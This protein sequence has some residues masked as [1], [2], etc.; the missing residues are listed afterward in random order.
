M[1]LSSGTRLGPYEILAPLGAGGMGEVYKARDSRLERTVAIKVLPDS[2]SASADA[3][4]RLEREARSISQLSHPNICAL[5][6]VGRE[7]DVE[8]LVMEYL[9][10][11]TL[12]ERLARGPLPLDLTLRYGTEIAG[13]LSEAHRHGIVHRDLK[14]GNIMLTKTGLKLLDFGLAKPAPFAEEPPNDGPTAKLPSSSLTAEGAIVGTLAYMAPEQL[15]GKPADTR[16]DIFAFGCVLYEMATG[17]RAFTAS[18]RASL[19]SAILKEEPRPIS[20]TQPK[21]PPA[22]ERVAKRCLAKDPEERWQSASDLGSELLWIHESSSAVVSGAQPVSARR[23]GGLA[24]WL[25]CAACAVG[26]A[27]ALF[28]RLPAHGPANLAFMTVSPPAGTDEIRDLAFSPDGRQLAVA[29]GGVLWVRALDS[30]VFR[31]VP[32]TDGARTVFWSPDGLTLGFRSGQSLER[33]EVDGG[34][35]RKICDLHG[36]SSTS[37]S[38][39]RASWGRN[40][41]I[42]FASTFRPILQVAADGGAPRN[43]SPSEEQTERVQD[44]EFLPDAD[45]YLYLSRTGKSD[46]QD[47]VVGSISGRKVSK[48]EAD[49]SHF[50]YS[51]DGFV[52]YEH[53]GR[54]MARRL[55]PTSFQFAEGEREITKLSPAKALRWIRASSAGFIAVNE[56]DRVEGAHSQETPKDLGV[57]GQFNWVTRSGEEGG[58]IGEGRYLGDFSLSPDGRRVAFVDSSEGGIWILAVDGAQKYRLTFRSGGYATPVWSPKGD[59]VAFRHEA[60][61]VKEVVVKS[62]DSIGSEEVVWTSPTIGSIEDWSPDGAY[63]VV[64]TFESPAASLWLLPTVAGQ[65][66]QGFRTNKLAY[67]SARFSPDGRWLAYTSYESSE[68]IKRQLYVASVNRESEPI[69]LGDATA[70]RWRRDGKELFYLSSDGKLTALKIVPSGGGFQAAP[71]Q[72]LFPLK[73]YTTFEVAP[74]GQRFLVVAE[75]DAPASKSAAASRTAASATPIP[76]TAVPPALVTTT[77]IVNWVDA[78][79]SR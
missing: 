33:V 43:A 45:H 1:T 8:Y 29:A 37:E 67:S 50:V 5:Y 55:N 19:I 49:V 62:A 34:N 75:A 35:H 16:T 36:P 56:S 69:A 53:R 74:D 17:K 10:G 42:L 68:W 72:V 65:K 32:G 41:V 79:F 26:L 78:V 18:S 76:A 58:T 61:D 28:R 51:P 6:D 70:P 59:K 27:F 9:E 30:E 52:I 15:E 22:F 31:K 14:P 2:L 63:L 71:P 64:R 39:G 38:R 73:G 24:L 44:P 54:L 23:R 77:L 60:G 12:S 21:I 48:L 40:G 57:K 66:P 3:R 4:R 47:L 25:L 13:A 7:A 46:Q 20:E 11:E